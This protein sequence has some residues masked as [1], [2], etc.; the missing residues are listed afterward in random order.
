MLL[1]VHLAT[2]LYGQDGSVRRRDRLDMIDLDIKH[3]LYPVHHGLGALIA[4]AI[5]AL[6]GFK[7]NS[8]AGPYS[9]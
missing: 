3:R 5:K 6:G 9:H 4:G 8:G 1:T 2:G 7:S